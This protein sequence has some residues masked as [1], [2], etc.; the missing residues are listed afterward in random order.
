MPGACGK[1]NAGH[2]DV[3]LFGDPGDIGMF[4]SGG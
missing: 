1:R 2:P 3:S 4:F